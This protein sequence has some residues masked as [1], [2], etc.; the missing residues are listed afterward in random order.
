[1]INCG[2]FIFFRLWM[3]Y[4]KRVRAL[5]STKEMAMLKPKRWRKLR[6]KKISLRSTITSNS[7]TNIVNRLVMLRI[8]N[9]YSYL[10]LPLR[11]KVITATLQFRAIRMV[12]Y[13]DNSQC[14]S[15]CRVVEWTT[16]IVSSHCRENEK[17]AG[18]K[19]VRENLP[20][21]P[22]SNRLKHPTPAMFCI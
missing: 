1:M 18:R 22:I 21:Y 12:K 13:V 10:P 19:V 3:L 15:L 11:L 16:I 6:P 5:R 2:S 4:K 14:E 7:V 20:I 9:G 8:W 17:E